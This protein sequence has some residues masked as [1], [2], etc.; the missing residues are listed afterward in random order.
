MNPNLQYIYSSIF[1]DCVARNPLYQHKVDEP[2][3]CPLFLARLE[4]YLL[5]LPFVKK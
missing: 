2:I 1:V 4:E 5:S 3:N